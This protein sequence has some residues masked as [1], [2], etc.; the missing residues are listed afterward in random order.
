MCVFVCKNINILWTMLNHVRIDK[1]TWK[2]HQSQKTRYLRR[3]YTHKCWRS[4]VKIILDWWFLDTVPTFS[5][6]FLPSHL[7]LNHYIWV[8]QTRKKKKSARMTKFFFAIVISFA[9]KSFL[10]AN[11]KQGIR[12]EFIWMVLP[13]T[14]PWKWFILWDIFFYKIR[15][16]K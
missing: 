2:R 10:N 13:A 15:V 8:C 3:I 11:T 9:A 12:V 4:Y 6:V 1:I 14:K 7:F 5:K 16:W